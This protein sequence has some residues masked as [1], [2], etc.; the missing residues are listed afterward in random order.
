[1]P[2]RGGN[3]QL[4]GPGNDGSGKVEGNWSPDGRRIV[5]G[6]EVQFSLSILD[7][8]SGKASKIPGS[9]GLSSPRW[10]PDG[11]YI[12]AMNVQSRAIRLFDLQTQQWSALV[13]HLGGW[14]FPTWSHDGRFIYALNNVGKWSVQRISVPDGKLDLVADLTNVHFTGALG[15]WFGLDPNDNPVLLRDNGTSDIYALTFERK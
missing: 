2:A 8:D 15:P 9:D 12:A 7:L 11:R 6:V 3:P 10:S 5:Y 1:V 4:L 13:E 14:N